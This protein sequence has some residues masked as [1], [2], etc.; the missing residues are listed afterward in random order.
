M[1]LS[2]SRTISPMMVVYFTRAFPFE[3]LLTPLRE[4]LSVRMEQQDAPLPREKLLTNL[5]DVDILVCTLTDR[6]D[7]EVLNHAPRL[8]LVAT[9]S[10][11]YDHLDL[12]ALREREIWAT[13]TPDVLTDA[14][15]DL[16]WALI[17]ATARRV[18][19][20]DRFVRSGAWKGW[21]VGVFLGMELAGK[22]LG[23]VGAGRIGQAVGR[24]A[25]GFGLSILYTARTP[26]P[27]FEKETGARFVDLDTLLEESDI[28][29]VHVPLTPETRGLLSRARLMRMKP[30]SILVNTARGAVVDEEALMDL[31]EE[32]HLAGVGL[33]VYAREPF[34]PQRLRSHPRTV[35]LPHL[36]S[37]TVA[38]RRRMFQAVVE[39]V[40]S[41]AAGERPPRH[42]IPELVHAT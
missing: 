36:G 19:E 10:V 29:S 20:V 3:D 18:V 2:I 39:S 6:I 41:F 15:A 35:L 16:T 28:V 38:T 26:K 22:T 30:G 42:A 21:Q 31:L 1:L 34:V 13:H 27:N 5:R 8:Q 4:K 9:Y 12:S 32:G 11:G 40:L 17:L 25:A 23:I 37:A 14:T 7:R 24:R 33:D